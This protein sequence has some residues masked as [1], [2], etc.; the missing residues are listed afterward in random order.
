M[1][2]LISP[3][4]I[5]VRA[6]IRPKLRF[7]FSSRV[8]WLVAIEAG[9]SLN[10]ESNWNDSVTAVCKN[11]L[12][13]EEVET[14]RLVSIVTSQQQQQQQQQQ[15]HDD[16]LR[17]TIPQRADLHAVADRNV[18]ILGKLEGDATIE[19]KM[20]DVVLS[21]S[22]KGSRIAV[23]ALEGSV[24]AKRAIEAADADLRGHRGI[25]ILRISALRVRATVS[26][27]SIG[28]LIIGAIYSA[29]AVLNVSGIGGVRVSAL[30][31]CATV[32]ALASGALVSLR[33]ITGSVIMKTGMRPVCIHFD[34]PRGISS[35]DAEGDVTLTFTAPTKVHVTAL[36]RGNESQIYLHGSLL[37]GTNQFDGIIKGVDSD[38]IMIKNARNASGG[39]GKI[40]EGN[41]ISGFYDEKNHVTTNDLYHENGSHKESDITTTAATA[42]TTD[43]TLTTSVNV[44]SNGRIT[45]EVID[46]ATAIMRGAVAEKR[47]SSLP[48]APLAPV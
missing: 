42:T 19:S 29:H 1:L 7:Q 48:V 36:G 23:T 45:I 3:L 18:C 5:H 39:S 31:G 14:E 17:V 46:Y 38:E 11:N 15:Q 13:I 30:H 9:G 35:I 20:G 21:G 12:S 25:D 4:T 22:V 28:D 41:E 32:N 2:R 16:I 40:R 27:G 24:I 47:K 6:C 37:R 43:A 10:V 26:G 34:S 33:G 44:I 8:G